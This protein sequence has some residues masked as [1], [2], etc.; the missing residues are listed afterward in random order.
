MR[1]D[2]NNVIITLYFRLDRSNNLWLLWS[3][4]EEFYLPEYERPKL[5]TL[6]SNANE[7]TYSILIPA[8]T[9]RTNGI[10]DFACRFSK[11]GSTSNWN[12]R[13]YKNTI[14]SL[15]G[16]VQIASINNSSTNV[17]YSQCLRYF[18]LDSG[19]I[20]F[21]T[22][23]NQSTLHIVSTTIAEGSTT[24]NLAVDNYI[25]FAIQKSVSDSTICKGVFYK[26]IGYETN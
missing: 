1:K 18:R 9:F 23:N 10:I 8:N 19:N 22:I 25:L 5:K 4:I 17:L 13:M 16:A 24:F 11:I 15:T 2:S 26:L 6:T 20:Y 3:N 7:I 14:N 12:V 21:Y